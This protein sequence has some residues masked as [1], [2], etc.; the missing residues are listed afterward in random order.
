MKLIF[1]FL[2]L[3]QI[4]TLSS[5]IWWNL[6]LQNELLS[7][8]FQLSGNENLIEFCSQFS[9]LTPGQAKLCEL[10]ADHMA[11]VAKGAR[12]GIVECQHQFKESQWNCSTISNN[13]VFGN[14]IAK[15]GSRE[16]AFVHAI[17]AAGVLQAIGRSCRNGDISTCG[18]STSKRPESLNKDWVWGGCG[19]NV[20]YGYKFTKI[21]ADI[22]EK[23]LMD[24]R[25]NLMANRQLRRRFKNNNIRPYR[26]LNQFRKQKK[27]LMMRRQSEIDNQE[28]D[29]EQEDQEEQQPK[30]ILRINLDHKKQR[31]RRLMNLHN[32]EAGRRVSLFF[33]YVY[34]KYKFSVQFNMFYII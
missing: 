29:Q 7:T 25:Q 12:I 34:K 31:A 10:Y 24:S 18:C 2:F 1:T 16:S 8:Q 6:G 26:I 4:A 14:G 11:P 19:D 13:T 27:S 28:N 3:L 20:E 21:F 15:V 32:N 9:G 22:N 17:S 5:G 30:R 23:S 33:K